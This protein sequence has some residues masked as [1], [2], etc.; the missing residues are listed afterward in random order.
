M[1]ANIFDSVELSDGS[2]VA[3]GGTGTLLRIRPGSKIAERIP[4]G[5]FNSFVSVERLSDT[6]LLLFGSA[7]VQRFELAEQ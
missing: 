4:Y 2:V 3:V 5:N 1:T 6:E 7:G